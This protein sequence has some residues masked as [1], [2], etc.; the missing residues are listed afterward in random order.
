MSELDVLLQRYLET[1]YDAAGD[2][3]KSAF[4]SVLALSDTELNGYLLQRQTPSSESIA[5]VIEHILCTTAP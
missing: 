3:E 1:R 2:D 5:R 4:R